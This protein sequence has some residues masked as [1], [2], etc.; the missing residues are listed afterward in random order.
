MKVLLPTPGTPVMPTRCAPPVDAN[1][2][3][4]SAWA[5][6]RCSGFWLSTRVIARARTLRSPARIPRA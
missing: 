2:S 6:V 4:T 5:T 1:S 3:C